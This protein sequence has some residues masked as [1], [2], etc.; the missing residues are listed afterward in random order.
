MPSTA[1]TNKMIGNAD[2]ISYR[3]KE[4]KDESKF[5]AFR[6]IH[7]STK[8]QAWIISAKHQQDDAAGNEH[9]DQVI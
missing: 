4:E 6:Q 3:T 1:T 9:T 2:N 5:F 7:Q 8:Q